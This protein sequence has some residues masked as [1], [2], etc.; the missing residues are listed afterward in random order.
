MVF[1]T[2]VV[3][4]EYFRG[5]ITDNMIDSSVSLL[6]NV[7]QHD[8]VLWMPIAALYTSLIYIIINCYTTWTIDID[9][10]LRIINGY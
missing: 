6:I 7:V 9:T 3:T 8:D 5:N 2:S 1:K 10:Q 4:R